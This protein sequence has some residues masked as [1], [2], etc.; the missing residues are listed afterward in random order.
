[1]VWGVNIPLKKHGGQ[2]IFWIPLPRC[3]SILAPRR[4]P[5]I[6]AGLTSSSGQSSVLRDGGW[7]PEIVLCIYIYKGNMVMNQRI[8]WDAVLTKPFFWHEALMAQEISSLTFDMNIN[9]DGCLGSSYD[10]RWWFD[11]VHI[12]FVAVGSGHELRA[13]FGVTAKTICAV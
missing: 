13:S 1:M 5:R 3:R 4:R 11:F 12:Q 7:T 6:A 2:W 9:A 8:P 10:V